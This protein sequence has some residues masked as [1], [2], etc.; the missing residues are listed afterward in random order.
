MATRE[1]KCVSFWD[2]NSAFRSGSSALQLPSY[3]SLLC[4]DCTLNY[5]SNHSLGLILDTFHFHE[6]WLVTCFPRAP[7]FGCS[8]RQHNF[9]PSMDQYPPHSPR[10]SWSQLHTASWSPSFPHRFYMLISWQQRRGYWALDLSQMKMITLFPKKWCFKKNISSL[11]SGE[12]W[13]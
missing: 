7:G 1:T 2:S 6:N 9:L 10:V 13:T 3:S 4:H 11:L 8:N 5:I 12:V